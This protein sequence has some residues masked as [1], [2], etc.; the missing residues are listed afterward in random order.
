MSPVEGLNDVSSQ[1]IVPANLIPVQTLVSQNTRSKT[2]VQSSKASR[3]KGKKTANL[4]S[5]R[6]KSGGIISIPSD[7]SV[8]D[9]EKEREIENQK[10]LLEKQA[11]LKR[12]LLESQKQQE[13]E[14]IRLEKARLQAEAEAKRKSIEIE[15][16]L[17][18]EQLNLSQ[19]REKLLEDRSSRSSV[20]FE[21]VK[22]QTGIDKVK[23]WQNECEKQRIEKPKLHF[24]APEPIAG[25]S[26]APDRFFVDNERQYLSFKQQLQ[27]IPAAENNQRENQQANKANS[28]HDDEMDMM[29][30]VLVRAFDRIETNRSEVRRE[31]TLQDRLDFN[32]LA[33][34]QNVI[35]DLPKFDGDPVSFP[36]FISQ[37]E[38]SLGRFTQAENLARIQRALIDK[39]PAKE[40]VMDLLNYPENVPMILSRLT[41]MFGKPEYIVTEIVSKIERTPIISEKNV[42]QLVAFSTIVAN[43]VSTLLSQNDDAHLKSPELIRKVLKKLPGNLQFDWAKTAVGRKDVTL[44]EVSQ[45]ISSIANVTASLMERSVYYSWKAKTEPRK[46][47]PKRVNVHVEE[48]AEEDSCSLCSNGRHSLADCPKFVNLRLKKKWATVKQHRLCSNCLKDNHWAKECSAKPCGKGGCSKMHHKLL[49]R[50]PDKS[51]YKK[52]RKSCEKEKPASAKSESTKTETN[53]HVHSISKVLYKIVPVELQCNDKKVQTFAFLD[54]GSSVTLLDDSL[55]NK[56]NLRGTKD[57]LCMK[58]TDGTLKNESESMRC[59][60][61]IGGAWKGSRKYSIDN[62]RTVKSL[63]LPSQTIHMDDTIKKNEKF[64]KLPIESMIDARPKMII[65]LE[66]YKLALPLSVVEGEGNE[67]TAIKSRLGWYLYGRDE[68]TVSNENEHKPSLHISLWNGDEETVDDLHL[69]VKSFFTTENFG[70]APPVKPLVSTEIERVEKIFKETTQYVNGKYETGLFWKNDEVEFP[71]SL[72]MA[73]KRN[74][75]L[76]NK[77]KKDPEYAAKYRE[78]ILETMV[79]GYVRKLTVEERNRTSRKKLGICHTLE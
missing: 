6:V 73:I 18:M 75:C 19:R 44:V 31:T 79:K 14:N 45:W 71:P 28:K 72:Q 25:T 29:A 15:S 56:L 40:A 35:K 11:E 77:F 39:S 50:D 70:V 16:K 3:G 7:K 68:V 64:R 74:E 47:P 8:L 46:D 30:D 21:G 57:P 38:N 55:V 32:L 27:D 1:T 54:E 42:D 66:H 60:L 24:G 65:G 20:K 43:L 78:K 69:M 63:D 34:R 4:P 12:E 52:E 53:G 13:L 48:T 17:I 23:Q 5:S 41:D 59:S 33:A 26:R 49:H 22:S 76:E 37:V 62:V 51:H 36:L 67:L 61:K 10:R 2:S 9:A 58:W